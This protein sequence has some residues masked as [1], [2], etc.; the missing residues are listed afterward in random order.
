MSPSRQRSTIRSP[1]T[2]RPR[3][4]A[5]RISFSSTASAVTPRTAAAGMG[6]ALSEGQF[7]YGSSPA[8]LFLSI[9][10]G[11]PNGMPAWGEILPEFDDLGTRRLRPEHR[12]SAERDIRRN[13]LENA[14]LALRS[15]RRLSEFL[16]TR[17]SLELHERLQRRQKARRGVSSDGRRQDHDPIDCGVRRIPRRSCQA[18]V[19][20]MDYLHADGL[21]GA[22]ILPLTQGSVD[23][24][25]RRRRHHRRARPDR[26][27]APRRE[28]AVAETPLTGRRGEQD[29]FRSAS[30]SPRSCLS[31]WSSGL[32]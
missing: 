32:P 23:R 14:A 5:C 29:G 22:R 17:K 8:N 27:L 1:T 6:P 18:A 30:A 15:S 7:I 26:R 9:Y 2:R 16:Q 10:Q 3:R 21:M 28:A 11:R 24:L 12:S 31:A 13:D 20:P 19:A 25:S 4:A